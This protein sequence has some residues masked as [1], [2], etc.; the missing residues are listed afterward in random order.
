MIFH[1]LSNQKTISKSYAGIM[2]ASLALLVPMYFF[3]TK[4]NIFGTN[5]IYYNHITESTVFSIILSFFIFGCLL[6]PIDFVSKL[7]NTRFFDFWNKL[8]YSHFMTHYFLF[9]SI[10][11][12]CPWVYSIFPAN[13]LGL[14][15]NS[16]MIICIPI[17]LSLLVIKYVEQP[18]IE[19]EAKFL[20]AY[21]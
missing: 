18:A 5:T 20:K 2:K 12:Y 3:Y 1:Y 16:T 19:L 17:P 9:S 6:E 21:N 4:P 10:F 13:F 15:F 14:L 8:S 11:I 7:G